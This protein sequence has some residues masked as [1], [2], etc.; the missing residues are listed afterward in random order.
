MLFFWLIPVL[1]IIAIAVAV[2][3]FRLHVRIREG[4]RQQGRVLKG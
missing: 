2:V 4:H 3:F 1:L